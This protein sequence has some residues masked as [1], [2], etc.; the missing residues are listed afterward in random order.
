KD[1]HLIRNS[2]GDIT[3][4]MC[5]GVVVGSYSYDAWGN[6]EIIEESNSDSI[7]I[8]TLYNNP[9]RY[10]GYYYDVETS[11]FWLSSRYY[12]PELC[13]FISPDDIEYLDPSSVNG[14]NL[15]SYANNNPIEI[16]YRSPGS[17]AKGGMVSSIASS[18]GGLNSGYH[19]TIS[20]SSNILGALGTLSTA[21]GLFDQWSGYLRGG[22]DAGLAYWGP[23]GFGFQFL[24]KYSSAL[25]KFGIGMTIAGNVLS[26]GRSV[27]NNFNNPNYTTGEAIG[28]SFMDAAYYTGKGLVTYWLGSKV[29]KLAVTAGIAAG[30]AALGATVFGT[31]IGFVGALAIGGGVAVLVGIAGA[32][33]IYFLGE[34][35][36]EGWELL[37]KQIFE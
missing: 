10:R 11:L 37:K 17:G 2:L 19:G 15:Y 7:D 33:V 8:D 35:I 29:G 20:N 27:Y 12:S 28:A 1:Y 3:K 6:V 9:F 16:A 30:S 4:L 21:F 26:W 18:V 14:L 34:C 23:K 32:A 24:S 13:R 5:N 22:L 36:D 25:K 31:T